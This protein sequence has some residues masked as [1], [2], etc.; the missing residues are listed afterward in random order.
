MAAS[1]VWKLDTALFPEDLWYGFIVWSYMLNKAR[2]LIEWLVFKT[3]NANTVLKYAD[4]YNWNRIKVRYCDGSSF[5]GDVERVD[6]VS[7]CIFC[8]LWTN[9][10][11][12]SK[13]IK[14]AGYNSVKPRIAIVL[15][16][17]L[18]IL[19]GKQSSLSGS[20]SLACYHWG[21]KSK[22]DEQSWTCMP[23]PIRCFIIILQG[24]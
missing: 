5:T 2:F 14:N 7:C 8:L 1:C 18:W 10:F 17:H 9:N 19:S 23:V 13:S 16:F 6:P 20:E 21:S 11:L 15:W 3:N 24:V 4:F 22:R 12:F